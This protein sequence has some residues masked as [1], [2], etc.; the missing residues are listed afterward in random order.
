MRR[1]DSRFIWAEVIFLAALAVRLI[2]FF[3]VKANFPGWDSPTI[4]PLYHDL[5][6]R[7]IASG[8]LLGSGPFFRAPFY[9]YFLGLIYTIFGPSLAAAKIIQ[10]LIG[11]ASC[12]VVFLFADRYFGRKVAILSGFISALNWALIY[13]ED[14]LLL[15]SLL[16]LFSVLLLWSLILAAERKSTA[17]MFI[18]GALL[19]ISSI[20]RPNYLAFLPLIPL[21]LF[22]VWGREYRRLLIST[23]AVVLG[24]VLLIIP[25]T[26]RNI[27]VGHDAVLIASQGG[28]NFYIGNNRYA[29]GATAQMPEFGSTWQYSDAEYLAKSESGR[30]GK[31]MKQ[32]E[33]S[34][35]FYRRGIEFIKNEPLRWLGLMAIKLDYFWNGF[36]ISNNQNLYFY[37]RFAS[38][39]RILP[40]VFYII[41]PLSLIG[42]WL[43]FRGDA[44][45]R[46]TAY[47]VLI[48]M[49]T[50]IAFFVNSRFRLPVLPVLIILA[51]L[52]F[53]K[54]IDS[55]RVKNWRSASRYL[56]AAVVLLSL[57]AV[58][59][60]G[61]SRESYAMSHYSLG[62]VYLK[63]GLTDE[64]LREYQLSL[65]LA[66][67][68]PKA[69][70][71]RGIIF[72]GRN[73][74]QNA[75]KE[76][77]LELQKCRVSAEA[78][79][80]L[81]VLK[82][83]AGDHREALIQAQ[84]AIAAKPNY[85]EAYVN[86]ILA[87]RHLG[88]NDRA[89]ATTDSLTNIFPEFLAGHYFKGL[90]LSERGRSDDAKPE[91][92]LILKADARSSIEK[93][94]LS[95]IYS[96]QAGYGYRP[97]R[98]IGLANYEM[99]LLQIRAEQIDSGLVY[100]ER[101]V[102]NIPNY[103]DAWINLAL[104]YDHKTMYADA[105]NAFKKAA[106]LNPENPLIYY[107]CGLT[108]GK[109]G[110]LDEAALFFRQALDLDPDF[111]EA[112]EKLKLTETIISS[113]GNK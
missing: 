73:D 1:I 76:F 108:L 85:L 48:Y 13:H 8:D 92:E 52:G 4:D 12:A 5:W 53:W 51:S 93:Y 3:Q 107:N 67:C 54:I 101:A 60:F 59:F 84:D 81:S 44:R 109:I 90:M 87:L 7:Q 66:G 110:K 11:A 112:E 6:A 97:E 82:R 91:F 35:F 38:I 57:T 25:V 50:V 27:I 68:V 71:N 103:V 69:H 40:P 61:I 33:V 43:I 46:I 23:A 45:F 37:R 28:I 94:D 99:G 100:F 105:L 16:V 102:R 98:V 20:T 77:Y 86:E 56:A 36:E 113:A 83:L 14:E 58:D 78:H 47:F 32:S 34:A 79:N 30:L 24:C 96:Q 17:W 41:S 104:A 64:A 95:T 111:R 21:W 70:L 31:E 106:D 89:F 22:F 2:Y 80:N 29:D 26:L 88:E 72:F 9:A 10:H 74:L 42:L 65:G 62:N 49:L 19:G 18:S 39:T 55:A 75:E 63:K 15:D